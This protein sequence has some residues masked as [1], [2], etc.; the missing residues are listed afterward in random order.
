MLSKKEYH[1]ILKNPDA[2]QT[3][4]RL[5]ARV[6]DKKLAHLVRMCASGFK[7]RALKAEVVN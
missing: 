7:L 4:V 3:K 2:R 1:N 6:R 5:E